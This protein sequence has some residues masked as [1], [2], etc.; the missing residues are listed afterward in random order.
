M[1]KLYTT[2]VKLVKYNVGKFNI[3]KKLASKFRLKIQMFSSE[4]IKINTQRI[5]SYNIVH[6]Y[7]IFK[8]KDT[9]LINNFKFLIN[10]KSKDGIERERAIYFEEIQLNNGLITL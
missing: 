7:I 1:S 4:N 5:Y 3:K 9:N 8:L 10:I 2:Q 6:S